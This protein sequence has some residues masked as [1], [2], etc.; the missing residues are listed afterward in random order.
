LLLPGCTVGNPEPPAI[1]GPSELGLSIQL[2][3]TPDVL[4]LDGA[5][6]SLIRIL[7]RND[8]G[9]AVPNVTI[10]LR[11]LT[12]RGP[13][14]Y[15]QLSA[16]SVV[17]GS[18][19]RA[20]VTYTVPL[21]TSTVFSL[22]QINAAP[23]GNDYRSQLERFVQIQLVPPG[24]VIPAK[25]FIAGFGFQ[26][27]SPNEHQQVLFT[28]ACQSD[29]DVNCVRNPNGLVLSY[30]W[31]FGDGSTG[32]G[33][34][35]THAYTRAG[36]YVAKLTITDEYGRFATATR[37]IT[38]GLGGQP[39]A[40]FSFSPQSPRVGDTVFFN[41]SQTVPAPG[42]EIV[43][44]SWD[45]GDGATGSGLTVSHEYDIAAEYRVTLTV[46]DNR[47]ASNSTS[48]PLTVSESGPT[49]SFTFSPTEPSANSTVF[50]NASASFAS[51][52]REI[53]SYRWNFGD[54]ATGSNKTTTH[55]YSQAGTFVVTL[56]VTD[57]LGE[58]GIDT[59]DVI[60]DP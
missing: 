44:Y 42:T 59:Q 25:K 23:V 57:N 16:R 31:D 52:G 54:G 27:P 22:V 8:Q 20:A 36:S 40:A 14:D 4:P 37:T 2:T 29:T 41:A 26:P 12:V 48:Q 51:S 9:G 1:T 38:V 28:T 10:R 49:A 32:S 5:S 60:V 39:A 33:P 58:V 30:D 24:T 6:Q 3:A 7:A 56:V 35:V 45:F 46:R 55:V 43:S 21:P 15:G 47:G 50:F 53:V 17:T 18:D 19:G 11:I 34:E 13:E